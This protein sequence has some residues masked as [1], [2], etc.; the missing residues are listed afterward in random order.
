MHFNDIPKALASAIGVDLALSKSDGITKLGDH[1]KT[2]LA[3]KGVDETSKLEAGSQATAASLF[4]INP[5]SL[6]RDPEE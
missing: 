1:L 3:P 6:P 4:E 2:L 5:P